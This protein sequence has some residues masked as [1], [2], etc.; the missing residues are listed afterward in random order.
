MTTLAYRTCPLCEAMCGLEIELR[1]GDR[2]GAVRGDRAD[3]FSAG[4][5]CPKGVSIGKLHDDPERLRAPLLRTGDRWREVSWDE[6][7]GEIERRLPPILAEHGRNA[8]A[9]YLGNPN[10]HDLAPTLYLPVLIRALGSDYRFSASTLDQ[11]PKQVS[12]GLMFGT[13][14][15]IAI[16]DVDRTDYLLVLGA[17]PMVSN[18][19]LFTAP[20]LPGRLRRLR[21]RGGRLVVVD[22]RRTRTADV[23]DE[24]LP[25]RPGTDALFLAALAHE[26][27]DAGL[28]TLGPAEPH[29][30]GVA[31]VGRAVAGFAP[32][33][34]AEACGIDAATI[35]RVARELA[36]APSAA[37]YG[38]I[39]TTTTEFGTVA[40]WL[41]D[42]LNTLTGNLDRPGGVL[43]PLPAAGSPNTAGP[44]GVGRGI[45]VPGSR[46]T[47]VRGLSST[48]GEFPTA[49]LAEEIDTPGADGTRLR[50]LIT[51]A[52]NPA[53]S[54]PN[55][56][57]LDAAL[58]T[59]DFMVSVD[60]YLNETTRHADV[61]LPAPSPLARGH[62][63]LAFTGLAVRNVARWSPSTLPLRPT[64]QP[65]S[66]TLLRLVC[67]LLGNG[68]TPA[69]LD[70]TIAAEL[71]RRLVADPASRV[72]GRSADELLAAVAPR[73]AEERLLDLMLRA[74]PYGE[75]LGS[76]PDG[77]S[78]DVLAA[79]PHGIDLGPLRPRL[80]G[81]LRTPSGKVELAPPQL[82]AD[83]PR[84]AGT[85]GRPDPGLLLV[86]RRD[87]RS[88]N[89]W[90]HNLEP[91]V[92]GRNRCTLQVHPVDADRLRLRAGAPARIESAV[93]AVEAEVEVTDTVR[94]GVVSL[95]HGWGHDRPGTRLATAATRAGVNSNI[96]TDPGPL[97]PLSGTA[98][99]NG[100]PVTVAPIDAAP[101][102]I[103]PTT[104]AP[105]T[106][107]PS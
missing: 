61:I 48:L 91:L 84:L 28:V 29:L 100:I 94:E 49:V 99:L 58:S 107:S 71:A 86:G 59:L 80:P 52:G 8:V 79:H 3:V 93:G 72:A 25:I 37:V 82:L 66:S 87:L 44:A 105:T 39:G 69:A 33:K 9:T 41:V 73:R 89:S 56:T 12:S 53:L 57:R 74:G 7:F 5:L 45:R 106:A 19:S 76:H 68:L 15:S 65:V 67:V 23:A 51:V 10:V 4:Y 101:T 95:P 31:E 60:L 50:A 90:M 81:V 88:N 11:W 83:L 77:L 34:V 78:L 22:P 43:F 36:A 21:E 42:V 62:Y 18:G 1:D 70:D 92:K 30:V 2:P 104:A 102:T 16:P 97:D 47:R 17:N 55:A 32:D 27:F 24:H 46:R 40:S 85:L 75:G 26:L 98:R 6:A 38:R 20:D 103:A 64:E 63:D 14:L 13:E 54:A 35:R 96:L